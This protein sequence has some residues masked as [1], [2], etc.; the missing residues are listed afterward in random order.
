MRLH[1]V[2][3]S[4]SG[5]T[6]LGRALARRF[7][8]VHLDIDD[9][10]WEP[11][12]PPFETPRPPERRLALLSAEA[13]PDGAW[14]ASGSMVGWG[15]PLIPSLEGV[16]FLRV[17]AEVRVRRLRARELARF[18]AEALAP[19]GSMHA[20]HREFIRWAAGY[21]EG[22]LSGRSLRRHLDWLSGLDC[23]VLTLEG[24]RPVESQLAETIRWCESWAGDRVARGMTE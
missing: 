5:T 10:Y 1:V 2:G 7:A 19:G 4:G 9:F 16:A 22:D 24:D 21:D 3:A 18:G 8:C 11:T 17:D 13:R 6:T 15:D 12:D 20:N 14:I 23:P